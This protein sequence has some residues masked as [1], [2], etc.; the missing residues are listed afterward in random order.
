MIKKN[1]ERGNKRRIIPAGNRY[2]DHDTIQA[3]KFDAGI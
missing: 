1:I 3:G 2:R